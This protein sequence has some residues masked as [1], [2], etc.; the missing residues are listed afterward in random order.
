M[1]KNEIVKALDRVIT[2]MKDMKYRQAIGG[3]SWVVYRAETTFDVVE[4]HKYR[5][6]FVPDFP[7]NFVA[8]A[9]EV[10]PDRTLYG[11]DRYLH[12]DPNI[13]GR[14][15]FTWSPFSGTIARTVFI[16]STKKG[17]IGI[18]DLA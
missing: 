5:V 1:E 17:T 13:N 7:G 15:W 14:W 2:D 18:T 3:D 9:Y 6:D 10:D 11:S 8:K 12:P 16:Y 4:G